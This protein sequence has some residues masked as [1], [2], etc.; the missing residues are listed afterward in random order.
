MSIWQFLGHFPPLLGGEALP[1]GF[2]GVPWQI[3]CCSAFP[4]LSGF[5]EWSR[6]TSPEA[7]ILQPDSGFCLCCWEAQPI[8][9]VCQVCLQGMCPFRELTSCS[10]RSPA[11]NITGFQLWHFQC[12]VRHTAQLY[13]VAAH[14]RLVQFQQGNIIPLLTRN[15]VFVNPKLLNLAHLHL[16]AQLSQ[17]GGPYHYVP[18]VAI[19]KKHMEK[20]VRGSRVVYCSNTGVPLTSAFKTE[21]KA[22]CMTALAWLRIWEYW[23]RGF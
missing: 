23:P 9:L 16:R 2:H 6:T 11:S 20:E 7:D 4:L 5:G 15:I 1:L 19:P 22:V 12:G 13:V 14:N 10:G 18:H 17:L 21:K 8:S 3:P